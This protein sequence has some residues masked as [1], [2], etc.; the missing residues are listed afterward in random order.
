MHCMCVSVPARVRECIAC[1][2]V[3]QCLR[4]VHGS[5]CP[6]TVASTAHDTADI[7]NRVDV[8]RELRTAAGTVATAVTVSSQKVRQTETVVPA[9]SAARMLLPLQLFRKELVKSNYTP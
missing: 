6:E 4:V 2:R 3:C 1:V 5:L 7:T 9:H 8:L